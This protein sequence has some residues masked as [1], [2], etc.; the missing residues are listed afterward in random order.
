MDEYDRSRAPF[1]ILTQ[2]QRR[3]MA[4]ASSPHVLTAVRL[5]LVRS[6]RTERRNK[7][8]SLTLLVLYMRISWICLKICCRKAATLCPRASHRVRHRLRST[9]RAGVLH[10]NTV[11][12]ITD[13]KI[14]IVRD[15]IWSISVVS[16]PS[17]STLARL[18]C[19]TKNTQLTFVKTIILQAVPAE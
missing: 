4:V 12:Q 11:K 9:P 1:R 6:D 3:C 5:T 19:S 17:H 13:I 18:H 10:C 16:I 14:V 2:A 8:V 15:Q 7:R